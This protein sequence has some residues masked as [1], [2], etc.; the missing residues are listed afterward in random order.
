MTTIVNAAP[1]QQAVKRDGSNL[2]CLIIAIGMIVFGGWFGVTKSIEFAYD[3]TYDPN[4][5]IEAEMEYLQRRMDCLPGEVLQ[6]TPLG[7]KGAK[8]VKCVAGPNM[9]PVRRQPV[10]EE[11]RG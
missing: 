5:A 10:Q 3:L 7:D 2:G 9:P 8:S 4:V 11:Q 1:T 6:I